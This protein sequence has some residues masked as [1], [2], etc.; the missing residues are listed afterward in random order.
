MDSEETK[1]E[2]MPVEGEVTPETDMPM[3]GEKAPAEATEETAM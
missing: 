2:G 1:V 3:E